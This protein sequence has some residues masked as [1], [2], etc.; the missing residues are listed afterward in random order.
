MAYRRNGYGSS[1]QDPML[2]PVGVWKNT[3]AKTC[4]CF[5][6]QNA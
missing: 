3:D 4:K 1:E 6:A 5:S 2:Y